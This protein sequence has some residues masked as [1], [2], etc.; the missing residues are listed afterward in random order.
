MNHQGGEMGPWPESRDPSP[1]LM[2]S[3]NINSKPAS[4][5]QCTLGN[6]SSSH[7]EGLPRGKSVLTLYDSAADG[8]ASHVL[9]FTQDI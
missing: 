9:R 1:F 8:P 6:F 2:M 5:P 3:L 4:D 7:L